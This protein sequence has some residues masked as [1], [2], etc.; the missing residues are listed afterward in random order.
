MPNGA[1]T[2]L[3]NASETADAVARLAQAAES[4]SESDRQRAE[5]WARLKRL[6][7]AL[8]AQSEVLAVERRRTAALRVEIRRHR[9]ELAILR[10][11]S[12]PVS[13]PPAAG[14]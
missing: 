4:P 1:S 11:G 5:A 10:A 2:P 14:G 12:D 7:A 9:A 8:R 3:T 13:T 6:S